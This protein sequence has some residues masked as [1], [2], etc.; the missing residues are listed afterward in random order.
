MFLCMS[1]YGH[2]IPIGKG[3]IRYDV[4]VPFLKYNLNMYT[5]K[6]QQ[7]RLVRFVLLRVRYYTRK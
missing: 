3:T 5:N 7:N 6:Q 1:L 2:T 4:Y